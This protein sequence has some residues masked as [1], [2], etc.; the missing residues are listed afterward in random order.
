MFLVAFVIS[1]LTHRV[2]DQASAARQREKNT[3]AIYNLSR[4]FVHERGIERL[5]AIAISH[6]SEVL[7]SKVVVLVPADQE[8]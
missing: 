5:C 7:S 4:K 8:G 3:A 2:R 6:I 1:R